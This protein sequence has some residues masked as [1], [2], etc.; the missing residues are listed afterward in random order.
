M[1][2]FFSF[3]CVLAIVVSCAKEKKE[4]VRET[5]KI[6]DFVTQRLEYTLKAEP[7]AIKIPRTTTNDG[8]LVT[9]GKYDWTSGFFPGN[10]WYTYELTKDG[11]WKDEAIKRTEVLDSIQYWTGNHDVGFIIYCSYGNG[12]KF[13]NQKQYK[14]IIIQTAESLSERYND[15]TKAIKSWNR[16]KSWDGTYWYYPVIIDNMMNLELLFEASKLSGNS[17]FKDIA[18]QHAETTIKNHYRDDYSSYHVVNYDTI[19]G[20]VLNKKTAQGFADESSWSRGQAWGLYGYTVSYRYTKDPKFLDF[21]ENIANYIIKHP[22]LPKDMVPYWDYDAGNPN[23]QPEWKYN[24]SDFSTIPRDV[25]AAAITASALYELSEYSDKKAELLKAADN[26]I[27]SLSSP[28]YMNENSKNKFF[29][30]DHSVGSIPHGVEIDVPLVY[31]DYYYLE[32]L[33]RKNKLD[34][35]ETF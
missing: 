20:A 4:K 21:A 35:N 6:L 3:I 12:L 27:E 15:T 31:A 34:N 29:I 7:D 5:N 23:F 28:S 11:K 16:Q 10:L 19:T 1:K 18:I 8:R 17:K 9:V 33:Y 14:D 32:A 30:L 2:K 22:N 24:E 13:G 25:S 26:I